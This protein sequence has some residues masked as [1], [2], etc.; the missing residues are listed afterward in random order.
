MSPKYTAIYKA[1]PRD[2]DRNP[3]DEKTSAN[4]S[5]DPSPS[6]NQDPSLGRSQKPSFQSRPRSS[7]PKFQ[8]KDFRRS[9]YGE[10]TSAKVHYFGPEPSPRPWSATAFISHSLSGYSPWILASLRAITAILQLSLLL[11]LQIAYLKLPRTTTNQ[12]PHLNN[13][14]ATYPFISCVGSLHLTP[15]QP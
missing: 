10:P 8:V 1:L 5:R 3:E 2:N 4:G 14:Y 9:E 11:F 6:R 13:L 7:K 12:L 15:Y